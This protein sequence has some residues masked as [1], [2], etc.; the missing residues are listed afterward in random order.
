M[1]I[2]TFVEADAFPNTPMALLSILTPSTI[3]LVLPEQTYRQELLS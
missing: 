2:E 1:P 3:R